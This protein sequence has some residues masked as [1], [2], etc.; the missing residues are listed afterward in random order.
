GEEIERSAKDDEILQKVNLLAL[1]LIV[2]HVPEVVH[3]W[4][5]GDEP[6]HNCSWRE[7]L[8]SSECDT[9]TT[10]QQHPTR[11]RHKCFGFWNTFRVSVAN[12][13]FQ[14]SEVVERHKCEHA[15]EQR[16]SKARSRETVHPISHQTPASIRCV[17]RF[18]S[19]SPTTVVAIIMIIR[20]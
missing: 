13:S 4:R 11:K 2:L 17:C 8:E 15:A 5:H 10:E 20:R 16:A 9:K 18:P 6:R 3:L 7:S 19:D 12:R 14:V 1:A